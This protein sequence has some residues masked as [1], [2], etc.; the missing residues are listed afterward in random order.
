MYNT[1]YL[2]CILLIISCRNKDMINEERII[3]TWNTAVI[4]GWDGSILHTD[5]VQISKT[6]IKLSKINYTYFIKDTSLFLIKNSDTLSY[7]FV[8][9]SDKNMQWKCFASPD[10]RFFNLLKQ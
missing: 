2:T 9:I 10:D 7:C 6:N 1:I 8:F 3:G 5:T 4:S